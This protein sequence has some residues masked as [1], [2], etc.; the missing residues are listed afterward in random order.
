MRKRKEKPEKK[1]G[2]E[3]I[4]KGV[5]GDHEGEVVH[6]NSADLECR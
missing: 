3:I 2:L 5:L 6:Y 4:V 1:D